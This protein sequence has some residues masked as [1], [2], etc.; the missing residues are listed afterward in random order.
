[1]WGPLT[2]PKASAQIAHCSPG[3]SNNLLAASELVDAGCEL[4]FHSTGC[5]VTYNDHTPQMEGPHH[6]TMASIPP[7]MTS[8]IL[9]NTSTLSALT[10]QSMNAPTPTNSSIST[11]QPWVTRRVQKFIRPSPACEQGHIDQRRAYL[12]STKKS[13]DTSSPPPDHMFEQP[14]TPNN[15][16][17]NM[18]YMTKVEVDGQLFTDQTGLFPVTSNR[19]TAA[20][21]SK[22]TQTSL[23]S[24]EYGAI[25]PNFTDWTT[26]HPKMLKT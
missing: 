18:V 19:V 7:S 1:M 9:H 22:H 20:N 17:T 10:N 3:I 13:P 23:D 26:K 11:T 12:H 15:D 4:F 16:K 24:S 21:S 5:K 2:G 8:T 25:V 14:Q 6:P